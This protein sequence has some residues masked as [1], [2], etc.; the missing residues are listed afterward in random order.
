MEI[1]P[2]PMAAYILQ[3]S[4]G[5]DSAGP[6]P[7]LHCHDVALLL[8]QVTT[9]S[10]QSH[11]SGLGV[12]SECCMGGLVVSGE[13][14]GVGKEFQRRSLSREATRVRVV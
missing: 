11:Q 13:I 3:S 1:H 4:I 2:N 10:A 5:P 12:W 14:R 7:V 9:H 8:S 6:C